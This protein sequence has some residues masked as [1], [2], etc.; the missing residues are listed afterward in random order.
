[1]PAVISGADPGSIACQLGFKKGDILVSINGYEITDVIDY[2][3][4]SECETLE[5]KALCGG[6]AVEFDIEKDACEPLGLNFETY[7]I[8]SQR[9][10]KNKCI[11]CFIDQL[12]KGLRPSLYFKD[13]DARLSFLMGNYITLTNLSQ[14]DIDRICKMRISP[15]NISVHTTDPQ[16]R[17]KMMKNP[18]AAKINEIMRS[19]ADAGITMNC[20]IVLCKNVNDGEHLTRTLCDLREL[21]PAVS[22]VSVVP[23]GLSRH[24]KGLYPL[25]SFTRDECAK[26]ISD[27]HRISDECKRKLGVRL[28]YPSDEFFI[29][30][31][32]PLPDEQYYDGYPQIENG[33]GLSTSLLTEVED[34]VRSLRPND[35]PT[36][37][38]VITG[39]LPAKLMQDITTKIAQKRPR[40]NCKIYPI[41]NRFFGEE[42]TVAGLVTATDIIAQLKDNNL[43][44]RVLIPSSMLRAQQDMFLDSITVAQVEKALD[45][46]LTITGCDGHELV[47][48][49]LDERLDR[50]V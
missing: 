38:A 4:Y 47:E 13:D 46:K 10:C 30:G 18:N 22:S 31:G 49:I 7:L 16:L 44:Q 3:Y 15:I 17:V 36:E 26:V 1:M 27:I 24:R 32:V 42:I 25:E 41:V 48:K 45:R 21:Y 23:V 5:I 43:P 11:F 33:V 20:Q 37:C 19:F 28:F 12:P 14:K 6:Q 2:M 35:K 9:S 29:K 34:A 8:D 40:L 39:V 50:N